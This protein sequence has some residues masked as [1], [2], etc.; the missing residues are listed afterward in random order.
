VTDDLAR[1]LRDAEASQACGTPPESN[2][3]DDEQSENAEHGQGESIG[4]K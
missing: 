2:E 3:L 4:L 1:T